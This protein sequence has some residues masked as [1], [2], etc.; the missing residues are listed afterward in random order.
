ME[1]TLLD[2]SLFSTITRAQSFDTLGGSLVFYPVRVDVVGPKPVPL[3]MSGGHEAVM[4]RIAAHR[5]VLGDLRVGPLTFHAPTFELGYDLG[6]D[7]LY[8][9]HYRR[10]VYSPD[11]G[12]MTLDAFSTA[13]N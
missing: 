9:L 12:K 11:Y 3:N 1:N 5:D 13:I 7:A 6:G 8:R 2:L 4:Q 10:V